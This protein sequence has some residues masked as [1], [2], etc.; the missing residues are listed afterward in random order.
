MERINFTQATEMML[1]WYHDIRVDHLE[2]EELLCEVSMRAIVIRDDPTLSRRRRSLREHLKAEK[3][4]KMI[5]EAV[6]GENKMEEISLCEKMFLE[7]SETVKQNDRTV[8]A[9]CKTRL[10]HYAH[11]AYQLLK[12]KDITVQETEFL[13]CLFVDIVVVL[14]KEF[15]TEKLNTANFQHEIDNE[16]A[17]INLFAAN[18]EVLGPSGVP[19]NNVRVD[20][21]PCN[22]PQNSSQELAQQQCRL[23]NLCAEDKAYVESL[24]A[25][26]KE[27]ESAQ[28]LTTTLPTS[29]AQASVFD[30]SRP[31]VYPT[32]T[33]DSNAPINSDRQQNPH[34]V[35][36]ADQPQ[37]MQSNSYKNVPYFPSTPQS[38][39]QMPTVASNT[40]TPNPQIF[41]QSWFNYNAPTASQPTTTPH[42][43]RQPTQSQLPQMPIPYSPYPTFY[44][45]Q[46]PN[47]SRHTLPVSQWKINKY[48]GTDQGLKLNEFLEIVQTFSLAEHVS[49]VELFESAVHLFTGPALKWYMTMRSTGRF[50][51][52]EHL[53]LEL[54][55]TFMH[56]DLDALIK[57]K[58]YQRRQQRNE[59]FHE[60]YYEM[61]RLFRTMCVQI[62]EHEK[63]QILLQ[64][65]RIDYRKQLTFLP[66]T[67]L[68]TLIAAG[69]KIDSLNF[70]AYNKV[71]GIEKSVNT[72]SQTKPKKALVDN[73]PHQSTASP[74]VQPHPQKSSRPPHSP[75]PPKNASHAP[76]RNQ[77]QQ[78]ARSTLENLIDTYQPPPDNTCYNCGIYDHSLREC[79]MPR[80]VLCE[81]CGFRGYPF[82]NCP[83]CTKN[84]MSASEKRGS[85]NR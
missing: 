31:M 79:S 6:L 30:S 71:F 27:L 77:P 63:V 4:Q 49:D 25:R 11:R 57:M 80:A 43:N 2:N 42:S 35:S 21:G 66:I 69:Q 9:K 56:P 32:R 60:F 64:N 51:N 13:K 12:C 33:I 1:G 85:L 58:I 53:V 18:Q 59:S 7:I 3:E 48:D 54:K 47:P 67:D 23:S 17:L 24:H 70:S 20:S 74:P 28:V 83:Y 41:S 5:I 10:L 16:Q 14:A 22:Q 75:N 62:P 68:P 8:R 61:E 40:F 52:W 82:N 38:L 29:S 15:Y 19:S 44:P 36:F 34:S 26:I 72:V 78:R 45:V 46:Q 55:R 65:I 39:L 37:T 50:L 76:V 84:A 73:L 81:N